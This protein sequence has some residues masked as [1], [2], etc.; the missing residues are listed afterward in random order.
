V[1]IFTIKEDRK[2]IGLTDY[3]VSWKESIDKMLLYVNKM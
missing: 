2:W 1:L 3:V